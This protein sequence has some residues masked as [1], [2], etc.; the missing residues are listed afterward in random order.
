MNL[1]D[2]CL[3]LITAIDL[4]LN[5]LM[6]LGFYGNFFEGLG[7]L[8]CLRLLRIFKIV[9]TSKTMSDTLRAIKRSFRVIGYLV[10]AFG[11]YLVVMAVIG[12]E[13][14]GSAGSLN[15][16]KRQK[17]N[18]STFQDSL[19]T[20]FVIV[21]N[22]DWNKILYDSLLDQRSWAP[23]A[24]FSS[25]IVVGNYIFINLILAVIIQNLRVERRERKNSALLAQGPHIGNSILE[26]IYLNLSQTLNSKRTR[27]LEENDEAQELQET[28]EI[29]QVDE[30]EKQQPSS[31]DNSL[32]S[33]L[34][35]ALKTLFSENRSAIS[36]INDSLTILLTVLMGLSSP[37]SGGS[38]RVPT[39][40]VF[41]AQE[42]LGNLRFLL[43]WR[44]GALSW[45]DLALLEISLLGYALG[46]APLQLLVVFRIFVVVVNLEP[47]LGQNNFFMIFG[48]ILHAV[49]KLVNLILW[50]LVIFLIYAIFGINSLKGL[51]FRCLG[52]PGPAPSARADCMDLGGDWV[53]QD[54]N[55]DNL[56]NAMITLFTVS[57]TEG[58]V[59]IMWS[60][61]SG[62]GSLT[63]LFF[64]SFVALGGFF[65]SNL[66]SGVVVDQYF[67]ERER[68]LG[69]RGV[70][71]ETQEFYEV[72]GAVSRARPISLHRVVLPGS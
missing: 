31:L 1:L 42:L 29:S 15:A 21:S 7:G 57:T 47:L 18:F 19:L 6:G 69:V 16:E 45:V 12:H 53:N 27:F 63:V 23:V 59:D 44:G 66:F 13:L 24:Y 32:E 2:L 56:A 9:Q 40:G 64:V 60:G 30:A 4:G 33:G 34:R 17:S 43:D 48:S 61:V 14:Y 36:L 37:S 11:L 51:F 10:I 3:S 58:W 5:K 65:L 72:L 49:P 20:V 35:G 26:N 62:P 55:F 71:P 39:L 22:E 41:F 25:I 46:T 38:L 54:F 67:R 70:P 8:R 50:S 28:K 68:I 52:L